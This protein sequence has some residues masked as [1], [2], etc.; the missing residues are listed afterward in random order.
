MDERMNLVTRRRSSSVPPPPKTG[1]R[2]KEWCA[3]VGCC[4]AQ[5]YKILGSGELETVLVGRMRFILTPPAAWLAAKAAEQKSVTVSAARPR[6]PQTI[7]QAARTGSGTGSGVEARTR[8][9]V[10]RDGAVLTS[11]LQKLATK[12]VIASRSGPPIIED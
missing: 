10:A 6:R 4:T 9:Q 8:R 11:T 5:F 2:P 1:W 7:D 12:R 3:S